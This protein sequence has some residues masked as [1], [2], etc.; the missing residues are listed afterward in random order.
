M[1]QII[2]SFY[3]QYYVVNDYRLENSLRMYCDKLPVMIFPTYC[4][5][6]PFAEYV[7]FKI[8]KLEAV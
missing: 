5:V 3:Q 7:K 2:N 4:T 1:Q 8:S 6:N